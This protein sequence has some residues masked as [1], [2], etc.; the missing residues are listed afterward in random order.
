VLSEGPGLSAPV[1]TLDEL[2]LIVRKDSPLRFDPELGFHLYRAD[3]CL[4]ARERGLAVVALGAPCRHRSRSVGLF[5]A[6]L[7]RAKVFARKWVHRLPVATPC[8]VFDREGGLHLL[9]DADGR[10]GSVAR[11]AGIAGLANRVVSEQYLLTRGRRPC[12]L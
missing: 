5:G 1:V 8:V 11:Q 3:L 12:I 7:D 4:Q 2:L 9:G 6:F 10:T